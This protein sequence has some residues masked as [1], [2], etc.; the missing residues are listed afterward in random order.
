MWK[1]TTGSIRSFG[2]GEEWWS[3]GAKEQRSRG[4]ES[5]V[6]LGMTPVSQGETGSGQRI[7][8]RTE[9]ASFFG[10][11]GVGKVGIN[12]EEKRTIKGQNSGF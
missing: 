4:A 12:E 3:K 6:A 8:T 1:N 7:K 5:L 10:V 2:W 9:R 11:A